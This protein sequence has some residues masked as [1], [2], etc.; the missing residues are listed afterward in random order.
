M[1]YSHIK[2]VQVPKG[3]SIN[4]IEAGAKQIRHDI[5]ISTTAAGSGHPSSS[6]SA[7]DLMATLFFGNFFSFDA[8]NPLN[9][10]NDRLIFSKGHA[11]PLLYALW[12]SA[13]QVSE[14]DGRQDPRPWVAVDRD[15]RRQKIGRRDLLFDPRPH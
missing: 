11:S 2:G 12:A 6:L 7:A 3:S 13:G 1:Q 8:K 10:N 4:L 14:K 5:L 15:R 9:Q